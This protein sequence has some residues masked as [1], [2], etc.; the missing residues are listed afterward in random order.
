M[1]L[2][3]EQALSKARNWCAKQER[4]HSETRTRLYHWGLKTKAV[5]SILAEL[6]SGGFISEERF[7]KQYAGGKFRIKKW[8]RLKILNHLKQKN[9]SE[10][11]IK[12]G[13]NEIGEKEYLQSLKN[14]LQ[15]KAKSLEEKPAKAKTY[16]GGNTLIKKNKLARYLVG[17]GYEAELVWEEVNLFFEE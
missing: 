9:I 1:T 4:S 6:I 10:Y 16:A 7:A 2:T 12:K 17:K 11:C 8:G 15:K 5:E 14:L 13:M 3:P